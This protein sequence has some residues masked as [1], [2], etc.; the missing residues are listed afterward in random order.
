MAEFFEC[1]MVFILVFCVV[2]GFCC[3]VGG[4]EQSIMNECKKIGDDNTRRSMEMIRKNHEEWDKIH[5]GESSK[6]S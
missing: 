1:I 6:N 3:I 5:N 2:F 4:K